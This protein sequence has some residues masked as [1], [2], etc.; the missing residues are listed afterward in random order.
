MPPSLNCPSCGAPSP[1]I[2]AS[3]C[4][5]CGSTLTTV[6][7]PHCFAAIFAGMDFC[8]SCGTR[9]D[10]AEDAEGESLVCP[11]CASE[12]RP[13]RVGAT[14]MHECA[15]CSSL[16]LA[17]DEFTALCTAREERG[18]VMAFAGVNRMAL[19][20]SAPAPV[21][22]Y[23]P[24]PVCKKIMNRQNFGHRSGVVIDVCKGHGVWFEQ[25]ELRATLAFIDS[26]GF[27]LARQEA[28]TRRVEAQA[29]L[30]RE[31]EKSGKIQTH[32]EIVSREQRSGIGGSTALDEALRSLF[33]PK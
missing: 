33:S 28:E 30:I 23:V 26:G 29:A 8:P 7:C 3:R 12:M 9:A 21:V 20:A 19:A 27:E 1:S 11:G 25:D 24:C 14:T 22:R 18:A 32:I 15:A 5:Y 6:S 2:G 10:R 13:L 31:F 4:T 16:W 17:A